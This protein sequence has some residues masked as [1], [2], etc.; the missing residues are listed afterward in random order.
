MYESTSK[1]R[2]L[3]NTFKMCT[4]VCTHHCA[5]LVINA[6]VPHMWD[7]CLT[8]L[9][10]A[11]VALLSVPLLRELDVVGADISL[12]NTRVCQRMVL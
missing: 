11:F 5:C 2:Y 8:S 10:Q 1:R 6:Y 12:L 3:T 7:N 9:V 4:Y